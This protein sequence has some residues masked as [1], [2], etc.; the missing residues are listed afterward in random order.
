M[1]TA[2]F[3]YLLK[4]SRRE[5]KENPR[6][7]GKKIQELFLRKEV[8]SVSR[9]WL[10]MCEEHWY[11]SPKQSAIPGWGGGR[12]CTS[13]LPAGRVGPR[14]LCW[15]M[16]RQQKWRVPLQGQNTALRMEDSA[17][18]APCGTV[19]CNSRGP[20]LSHPWS[21]RQCHEHSRLVRPCDVGEQQ[22]FMVLATRIMGMVVTAA[23]QRPS[24]LIHTCS[25]EAGH[26]FL[27]S[28]RE[29]VTW[30]LCPDNE[31]LKLVEE[32]QGG[33]WP[34]WENLT[35]KRSFLPPQRKIGFTFQA[36]V[37]LF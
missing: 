36:I 17:F 7:S 8:K 10:W 16:S 18:S 22:T 31:H 19:A 28:G 34:V 1:W 5:M 24:W 14:G 12:D 4:S 13:G 35:F 21:L 9:Y 11:C 25:R 32:R 20:L 30:S 27:W 37:T 2:L 23:Y 15:S 26:L 3:F 29:S 33:H 6:G